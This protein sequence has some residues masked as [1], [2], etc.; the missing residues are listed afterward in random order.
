MR[1]CREHTVEVIPI[2]VDGLPAAVDGQAAT[3]HKDARQ[4]RSERD[5]AAHA[6]LDRICGAGLAL[7]SSIASRNVQLSL[8]QIPPPGSSRL[9]TKMVAA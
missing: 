4:T 7:A 9:L 1:L 5:R 8:L 2:D 3:C 6:E